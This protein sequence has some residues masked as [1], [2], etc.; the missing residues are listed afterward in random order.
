LILVGYEYAMITS[1]KSGRKNI[2][3]WQLG[4]AEVWIFQMQP[5]QYT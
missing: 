2:L 4:L 5:R 3:D 1:K